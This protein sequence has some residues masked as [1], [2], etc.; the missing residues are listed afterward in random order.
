MSDDLYA[1]MAQ[2]REEQSPDL[3]QMGELSK[4][5]HQLM[6]AEDDI[7]DLEEK[8]KAAKERK[9]DLSQNKIPD[10][11]VELGVEK[12]QVDGGHTISYKRDTDA[13]MNDGNRLE[14]LAWLRKQGHEDVIKNEISV[15]FGRGEDNIAGEVVAKLEEVG[16][17]YTQKE[18]VHAQTL[19]AFCRKEDE[20]GTSFPLEL[21]VHFF[22]KTTV[23]RKR[24]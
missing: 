13:I 21:G 1:Q 18:S 24:G 19:R 17:N 3:G 7:K 11:M 12:I 6:D 14:W 16:A 23:R 10:L 4:L 20:A 15:L 5:A 8:L 9:T 2:D 22:N